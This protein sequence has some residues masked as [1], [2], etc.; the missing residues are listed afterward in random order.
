MLQVYVHPVH[1]RKKVLET[2]TFTIKYS[3]NGSGVRRAVSGLE[4]EGPDNRRSTIGLTTASMIYLFRVIAE[5][6][7]GL[8]TLIGASFL[9]MCILRIVQ[10]Y[11][12]FVYRKRSR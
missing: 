11:L 7:Q 9:I 3:S 2:Y 6:C 12:F 5:I 10:L 1:D 8:P 4:V